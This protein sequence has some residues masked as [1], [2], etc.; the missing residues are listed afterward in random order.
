MISVNQLS[1]EFGGTTLFDNVS[2][3]VNVKDRIGLTG[4][5]GAGKSTL[6]KILAGVKKL[7]AGAVSIQ[8][9]S[10]IGYLPQ[11]MVHNSGKTVYDETETAFGE[12]QKLEQKI[13]DL[14]E[15]LDTRTDHESKEYFDIIHELHEAN[16]R[17]QLIGGY[18]RQADIE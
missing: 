4:K 1:V 17:F 2:F 7:E 18:T 13:H 6:L 16:E 11:E 10:T 14:S 5:N 12:I 9:G 15:Q 8:K 3:L